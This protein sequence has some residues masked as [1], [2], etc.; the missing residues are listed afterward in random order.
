MPS[1][2]PSSSRY[3][4]SVSSRFGACF[5][6]SSSPRCH[7]RRPIRPSA[8]SSSRVVISSSRLRVML[9]PP[10][11]PPLL[12]EERGGAT[13]WLRDVGLFGCRCLLSPCRFHASGDLVGRFHLV[14][15]SSRAVLLPRMCRRTGACEAAV[16]SLFLLRHLSVS[17]VFKMLPCQSFKTLRFFDTARLCGYCG[18]PGLSP[19]RSITVPPHRFRADCLRP[20]R[21]RPSIPCRSRLSRFSSFSSLVQYDRQGGSSGRPTA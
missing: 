1:V 13:G 21:R 17:I 20:M 14:P 7:H 3:R 15:S 9:S 8:S 5:A 4:P 10:L 12:V 16:L 19:R 6:P 2:A 11:A 18:V